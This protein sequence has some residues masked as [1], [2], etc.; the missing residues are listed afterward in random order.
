MKSAIYARESSDDTNK[1]PPIDKQIQIGREWLESNGHEL[2]FTFADNGFSG[3]NWNRP[4]WN[5]AITKA[6]GNTYKILWVWNQD[7]IARDT[8]QF[9]YFYRQLRT[10]KVAIYDNTFKGFI[11]METLGGRVQHTTIAQAAEIFR[12]LT[13]DKVKAAYNAKKQRD[14]DNL[15]W[16]RPKIKFDINKAIELRKQG[17]GYRVIGKA[18]GVNYQTIRRMLLNRINIKHSDNE[19]V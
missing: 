5:N 6:K 2:V 8:E 10:K 9:L 7:R 11:D 1:A 12:I 19:L 4:E 16:G 13:S 14:G 18:I 3:G 15:V 17:L